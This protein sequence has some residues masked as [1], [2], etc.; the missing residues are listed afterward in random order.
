MEVSNCAMDELDL[1]LLNLKQSAASHVCHR[2]RI[3]PGRRQARYAMEMFASPLL[4]PTVVAIPE[5]IG[6]SSG[7]QPEYFH[8]AKVLKRS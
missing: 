5:P 1:V 8:G 6:M 2:S 4:I 7:E 3:S